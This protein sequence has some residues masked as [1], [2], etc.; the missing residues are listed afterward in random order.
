MFI[1]LFQKWHPLRKIKYHNF[2]SNNI[3]R[4]CERYQQSAKKHI[5]S[6]IYIQANRNLTFWFECDVNSKFEWQNV[7]QYYFPVSFLHF[8]VTLNA[9]V[10]Y[11]KVKDWINQNSNKHGIYTFTLLYALGIG[12]K[13]KKT[14]PKTQWELSL[15]TANLHKANKM[16]II[17]FGVR[18]LQSPNE[19]Y[20]KIFSHKW[21]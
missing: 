7:N 21:F 13:K 14:V 8:Q 11:G 19:Q 4:L 15:P 18:S 12:R 6:T 16:H 9:D 10:L 5:L 3:L 17:I 2:S 20:S 1:E